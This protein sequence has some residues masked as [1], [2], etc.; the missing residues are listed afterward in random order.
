MTLVG[1]HEE[2]ATLVIEVVLRALDDVVTWRELVAADVQVTYLAVSPQGDVELPP[3]RVDLVS[4][5]VLAAEPIVGLGGLLEPSLEEPMPSYNVLW[6]LR[7]CERDRRDDRVRRL[8]AQPAA[9][10]VTERL[11]LEEGLILL[12][13]PPADPLVPDAEVPR[14][15]DNVVPFLEN[16]LRKVGQE[17]PMSRNV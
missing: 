10:P 9:G 11:F 7:R 12:R 14:N 15:G 1:L 4:A 17:A 6:M 16:G 3:R 2:L 5:D 8:L 13:I